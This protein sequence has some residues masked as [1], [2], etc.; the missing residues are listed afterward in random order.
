MVSVRVL[1]SVSVNRQTRYDGRLTG[2]SRIVFTGN[3]KLD[4]MLS[5]FRP[6]VSCI[7]FLNCLD[8]PLGVY[9]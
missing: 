9:S 8:S 3:F 1:L 2:V 6:S 5:L 4:R 7:H